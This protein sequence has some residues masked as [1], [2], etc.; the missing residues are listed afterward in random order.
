MGGDIH[1]AYHDSGTL[2]TLLETGTAFQ[3]SGSA[4]RA[5]LVRVYLFIISLYSSY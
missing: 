4:M 1:T 2:A 3:P 5:E